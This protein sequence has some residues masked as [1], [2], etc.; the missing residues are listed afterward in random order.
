MKIVSGFRK[1]VE[2]FRRRSTLLAMIARGFARTSA[3]AGGILAV[4]LM[5]GSAVSPA[6]AG[7]TVPVPNGDFSST[8]NVGTL[9][10]QLLGGAGSGT[11]GSGPWSGS[12]TS[13]L[14]LLLQPSLEINSGNPGHA[15]ISGIANVG[16]LG[17]VDSTASFSQTLTGVNYTANT[18]YTLDAIVSTGG[19]L[20]ASILSN[21]GV[22]IALTSSGVPLSGSNAPL[23]SVSLLSGTSYTVQAQYT[24]TG[25]APSGP[26]GIL[27][28]DAP[29]G[30][31]TAS[32]LSG[33]SF[34]DVSLTASVPEPSSFA[35]TGTGLLLA[36]AGG[37][38]RNRK[39]RLQPA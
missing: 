25:S 2:G 36:I 30:L 24:F 7:Y 19:L 12:Y 16:V 1:S 28:Y 32:L 15:T 11:F 33:V 27:L 10:G 21:A 35:M 6:T 9:G 29:Q 4:A 5:V 17:I 20:S 22:G 18:T 26:I 8:T 13:A 31:A 23:I 3:R 37:I 34:T 14:G 38:R 39:R